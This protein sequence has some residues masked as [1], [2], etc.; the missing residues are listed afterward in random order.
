MSACGIVI[1]KPLAA[2][3]QYGSLSGTVKKATVGVVRNLIVYEIRDQ[4]TVIASGQSTVTTGAFN[5]K[6]S[7]GTNDRFRMICIGESGENSEIFD[8]LSIF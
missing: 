6:I 2:K 1:E 7:G 8:D 4:E 5:L 3:L